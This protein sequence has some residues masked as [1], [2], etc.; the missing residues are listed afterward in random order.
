MQAC[1]GETENNPC[2]FTEQIAVLL[3][4]SKF[5]SSQAS[6]NL[7]TSCTPTPYATRPRKL[8]FPCSHLS[9]L[10]LHLSTNMSGNVLVG[11]ATQLQWQEL[12]HQNQEKPVSR[13]WPQHVQRNSQGLTLAAQND[14][15][16]AWRG[17]GSSLWILNKFISI[18]MN[19]SEQP[20]PFSP[21]SSWAL[22]L[23]LAFHLFCE[24]HSTIWVALTAL[25][26]DVYQE[27]VV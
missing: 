21:V 15:C 4:P 7:F 12:W 5:T 20:E 16:S 3:Y 14:L 2:G 24:Q 19:H 1:H 9:V 11:A 6:Q 13:F 27:I 25:V 18:V 26:A 10:P 23:I 17:W 22:I 8:V